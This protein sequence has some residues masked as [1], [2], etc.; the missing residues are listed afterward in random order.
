MQVDPIGFAGGRLN[1]HGLVGQNLTNF[2]DP[3]GH[4]LEKET[5]SAVV[6]I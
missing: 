5:A 4:C 1:L 2:F 3:K 6:A